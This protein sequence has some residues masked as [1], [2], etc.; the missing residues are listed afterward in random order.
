ML[1][2]ATLERLFAGLAPGEWAQKWDRVGLM[3]GSPHW[4]VTKVA[5][6]L[7]PEP[8]LIDA[9]IE[10][11]ADLLITHHPL[12]FNPLTKIET[13]RGVGSIIEKALRS[14]LAILS[15]HTNIDL[16]PEGLAQFLAIKLGLEN[17]RPACIDSYEALYKLVVFV[18]PEYKERVR[19]V[20]AGAGAGQIGAYSDTSFSATGIGTF[21]PQAGTNPFS[22]E[23]GSLAEVKEERLES[24][25]P[26]RKWPGVKEAML[27]AHPYEEVAY[28]LYPLA[29]PKGAALAFGR[30]GTLPRKITLAAWAREVAE[31]LDAQ[32][33]FAG[34]PERSLE[35]VCVIPG[36]GGSLWEKAP[37]ADCILTGE[38][39][40]HH[41]LAL[42]QAGKAAI[43][44]GHDASEVCFNDLIFEFLQAELPQL[45]LVKLG[46]ACP[47]QR[48]IK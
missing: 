6:A 1:T 23:I 3:V 14:K 31:L 44:V 22:G 30:Y 39:G 2:V 12:I 46:L 27:R 48:V 43:K 17:I 11:G 15:L 8:Q 24:I 29:E 9:A 35:T 38:L 28:D 20:L 21:L 18:P 47:W 10:A 32:V 45:K 41:L 37:A 36:S 7:D 34:D 4:E 13:D 26:Q 25:V 33:S 5:I 16:A 19:A 40:Y 42:R